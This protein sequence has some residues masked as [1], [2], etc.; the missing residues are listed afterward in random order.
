MED[1]QQRIADM[2]S[3]PPSSGQLA[4]LLNLIQ[5][6]TYYK[7]YDEIKD[8]LQTLPETFKVPFIAYFI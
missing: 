1:L 5:N 7:Y 8:L 2:A 4:E 6:P 3:G